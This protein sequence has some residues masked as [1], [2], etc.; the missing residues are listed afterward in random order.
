MIPGTEN[1]SYGMWIKWFEVAQQDALLVL[2]YKWYSEF[3]MFKFQVYGY[4]E[5]DE[6]L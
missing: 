2:M 3:F 5:G 4:Q 6:L 1:L